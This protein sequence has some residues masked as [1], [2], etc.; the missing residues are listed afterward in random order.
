LKWGRGREIGSSNNGNLHGKSLGGEGDGKKTYDEFWEAKSGCNQRRVPYRK[1]GG[2]K[3]V[4]S[5]E[6]CE[7]RGKKL[8][9]SGVDG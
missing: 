5:E 3:G 2:K 6:V 8:E 1:E 9:L 7:E 4:T